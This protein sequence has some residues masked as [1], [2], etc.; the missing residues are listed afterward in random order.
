[1]ELIKQI[2]QAE[3]Q[4]QE[5]IEQAGVEAARQ[6]EKGRENRLAVLT[7]AEQ[8]RKKAIEAAVAGS[9]SESLAEIEL[10]KAEAEKKRQQLRNKA[11]GKMD[12][13]AAKIIDCLRG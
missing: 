11:A 7:E 10:L 3:T 4:A 2:K 12:K 13:A 1:M 9:R 6:T 5:I 8:E